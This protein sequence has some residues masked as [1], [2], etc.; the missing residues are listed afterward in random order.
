MY[1]LA[2]VEGV[3]EYIWAKFYRRT[4]NTFTCSSWV[5]GSKL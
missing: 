3:Q 5:Y 2:V 1:V 4:L